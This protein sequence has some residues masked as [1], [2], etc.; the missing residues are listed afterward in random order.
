MGEQTEMER[1]GA[2]RLSNEE[3]NRLTRECIQTALLMLLAEKE[4]GKITVT[5][6]VRKAGVSRGAFYRNYESKEQVLDA[7]A[8]DRLA[9]FNAT[10]W[11][12][13]RAGDAVAMY[14]KIFTTVRDDPREFGLLVKAGVLSRDADDV[15]AFLADAF[16]ESPASARHLLLGWFGMLRNIVLDWYLDGMQ[17]SVEEM[18]R[19]CAEAAAGITAHIKEIDPRFA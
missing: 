11:A 18:S 10:A 14:R 3:S 2:L 19:L 17:E 6:V 1:H 12:A 7:Y 8:A 5:E 4:L 13:I 9:S 16:A 15:R